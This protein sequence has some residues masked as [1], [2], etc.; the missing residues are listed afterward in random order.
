MHT[1][2]HPFSEKNLKKIFLTLKIAP[3]TTK[4]RPL[5]RRETSGLAIFY[6]DVLNGNLF[7]SCFRKFDKDF[8]YCVRVS[9][10]LYES[11]FERNQTLYDLS[12]LIIIK[13]YMELIIFHWTASF[14]FAVPF[15]IQKTS[16]G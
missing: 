7:L 4:S 16:A 3:E 13:I 6:L 5:L 11:I 2:N 12:V 10:L 15:S 14:I 8:I 1:Q 9:T